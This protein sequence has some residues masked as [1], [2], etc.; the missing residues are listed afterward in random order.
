[1]SSVLL[2]ELN[3]GVTYGVQVKI[4]LNTDP[5][6]PLLTFNIMPTITFKV[7]PPY[8]PTTTIITP[9]ILQPS[10]QE[11]SVLLLT[12]PPDTHPSRRIHSNLTALGVSGGLVIVAIG[13]ILC[14]CCAK[15]KGYNGALTQDEESKPNIYSFP[16]TQQQISH[17]YDPSLYD[18]WEIPFNHIQTGSILGQG[19]F[20]KVIKGKI[21]GR[22]L[23]CPYADSN[24][25][26][27]YMKSRD[28][29]VAVKM[30][31]EYAEDSQKQ[32]FMREIK[33]MKNLGYHA[34]IV[35]LI[36]CC[37]HQDPICLV[38]EHCSKGDLL[39]F[40]RNRRPH[41]FTGGHSVQPQECLSPSDLLSFARQ[42]VLGMEYLSQKGFVHRDLAAR[43]VLVMEDQT[44]K[45]GDFGLTRFIYN[46]KVYI[47]KKGG[48]LPI[49]WMSIES[50]FDDIF[51]SQSDVWSFGI[52]LFEI[53]T[54]GS[55]PYP[56]VSNHDI[57]R[58]LK[59]GYIMD[60]PEGCSDELYA[61]MKCCWRPFQEDRP[62]FTDLRHHLENILQQD[63][64]YLDLDIISLGVI[65]E[66]SDS[67][68]SDSLQSAGNLKERDED[69]N[70]I[71]E[72]EEELQP[73]G[74]HGNHVDETKPMINGSLKIGTVI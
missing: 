28:I 37:T 9:T 52:L 1:M 27:A 70:D 61:V 64:P 56:G 65:E 45:I 41:Y 62:S 6:D 72:Q 34:N 33:L 38:V 32:E 2:T 30:L 47:N 14:I 36:A 46:D 21:E 73:Q 7:L 3:P 54:L 18:R 53:I 58:F 15:H 71:E 59:R 68:S 55:A 50:L 12:E 20:G 69:A 23:T 51:T 63:T 19:A 48:R 22:V 26:S 43:N 67:H 35:S 29:E 11:T 74:T 17:E 42:V 57:P 40:L 44:L 31:H 39:N 24:I 16:M 4:H 49:K 5:R 13:V 66:E 10:Q 25:V 60:Q 8:A